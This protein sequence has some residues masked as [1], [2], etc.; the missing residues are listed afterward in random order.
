MPLIMVVDDDPDICE[1]LA[2][3]LHRA[4]YE[5]MTAQ[6][7]RIA[8]LRMRER[9]PDVLVT[10][11]MMPYTDGWALIRQCRADPALADLAVLVMSSAPNMRAVALQ[12][13]AVGFMAKPFS[14][15]TLTEEVA[16]ALG[17]RGSPHKG[18]VV[19]TH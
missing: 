14:R 1:S 9:R 13:G 8:I 11:V 6:D 3:I 10:D 17:A 7:A 15:A 5:V 12:H 2:D 18:G 4:G 16:R 19:A